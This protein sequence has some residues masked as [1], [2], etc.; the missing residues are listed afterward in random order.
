[1]TITGTNFIVGETN[2]LFDD[3]P[4]TDVVV[5]SATT[6]TAVTPADSAGPADVIVATPGGESD[7]PLLFTFV[8]PPTAGA[9]A[10]P[11]GPL[12]G[13]NTVTASGTNLVPGATSVT[14]QPPGGGAP[15]TIPATAVTVSPDGTTA[16][17]VMP[18][19]TTPGDAAITLTTP[20]GTTAPVTYEYLPV[21]T[22]ASLLPNAFGP[23][24][25]GNAVTIVGTGFVAGATSVQIGSTT[26]PASQV[27]VVGGGQTPLTGALTQALQASLVQSLTATG[28]SVTFVAPAN[29]AGSVSIT[30]ITPGG[31]ST[32]ALT[33]TYVPPPTAASLSP[34][35][36]PASGGTII[37]ITGSGFVP[38][39]TTVIVT[40]P[41]GQ[42]VTIP[43]A[44]LGIRED[45]TALSLFSPA[46]GVAGVATIRVVTPGGETIALSFRYTVQGLPATGS[47]STSLLAACG[48]AARR[49][50]RLARGLPPALPASRQVLSAPIV[51]GAP[52]R[53]PITWPRPRGRGATGSAPPLQGGG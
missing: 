38:G 42:V 53:R 52:P 47:D 40:L 39:A 49:R 22:A 46:S 2:V 43:P 29:V 18:G 16:S 41:N 45:G 51:L 17:F 6:L 20:F 32:P 35:F 34:T 23:T 50:W 21:P 26:I 7:P 15:V 24:A 33:Y 11:S 8:A 13:G 44:N 31:T 48:R 36:G 9:V 25:G 28:T 1:M 5:T 19:S 3:I 10:P 27:S 37:T 14:V 12:A 4:A 30:V